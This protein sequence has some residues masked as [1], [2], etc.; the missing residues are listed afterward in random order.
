MLDVGIDQAGDLIGVK[1]IHLWFIKL[2]VPGNLVFGTGHLAILRDVKVVDGEQGKP[3]S[4]VRLGAMHEHERG[5]KLSL[6]FSRDHIHHLG[7]VDNR[8]EPQISWYL[9]FSEV[10]S[11][12]MHHGFPVAFNQTI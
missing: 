10:G 6:Q 3:R 11:W 5:C 12:Y 2:L 8:L 7:R 9:L 1:T 4:N